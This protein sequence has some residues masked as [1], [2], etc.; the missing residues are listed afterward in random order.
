MITET[1]EISE[2]LADAAVR[3]PGRTPAELLRRLA[4]EGHAALRESV[5]AERAAVA[6]TSGMLT[7]VYQPGHLAE[8]RAEW[9]A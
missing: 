1:G 7:G 8:L 9:P 2:A 3:W 4:A 6:E 5:Q